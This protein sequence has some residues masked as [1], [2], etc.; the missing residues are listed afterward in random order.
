MVLV[1]EP[2]SNPRVLGQSLGDGERRP[3][4]AAADRGHRN[5]DPIPRKRPVQCFENSP[6]PFRI[7]FHETRRY[8]FYGRCRGTGSEL[9][10]R[11]IALMRA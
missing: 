2:I 5:D 7:L 3:A 8:R 10:G 11:T 6:G 4:A 9:A 1:I